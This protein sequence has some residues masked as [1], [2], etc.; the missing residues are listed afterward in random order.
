[1]LLG[2]FVHDLDLD[3][4]APTLQRTSVRGV[5]FRDDQLLLLA[6]R[7]GDYKFPGGGVEARESIPA[8]LQREFLEEC[9]LPGVEIGLAIGITTEYLRAIE[10]EY[11]VFKLTSHYF[12]CSSDG[13]PGDPQQLEGYE[14]ELELEPRWVTVSEALAANRAV[15]AGGVG[16]MRWLDREIQVLS[17]L[18][19]L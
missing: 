12:Y 5:L 17:H 16:V 13:E 19:D 15:R 7:H 6:S 2:S 1:M 8:A 18:A 3:L 11:E 4:T 14:A 9:G 10:P